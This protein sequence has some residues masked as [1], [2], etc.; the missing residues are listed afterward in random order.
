MFRWF[1]RRKL[2]AEEKKLDASMDY[3]RHILDVSPGAFFR[4]ASIMPFANSLNKLP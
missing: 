2:A 4:F 3:L 1:L